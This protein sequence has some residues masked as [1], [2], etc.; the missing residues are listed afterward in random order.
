MTWSISDSCCSL[1]LRSL[2]HF[3]CLFSVPL[4]K[5]LGTQY[6]LFGFSS[7]ETSSFTIKHIDVQI[8]RDFFYNGLWN[9]VKEN[10][11]GKLNSIAFL[12]RKIIDFSI[13]LK[14]LWYDLAYK[15][16]AILNFLINHIVNIFFYLTTAGRFLIIKHFHICFTMVIMTDNIVQLI[17][18]MAVGSCI[19]K[20]HFY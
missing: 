18:T 12:S 5:F 3:H 10:K 16:I 14:L 2:L 17:Q 11:K 7:H 8:N 6:C 9:A 13:I 15:I 19:Q 1:Q 20:Y 4:L